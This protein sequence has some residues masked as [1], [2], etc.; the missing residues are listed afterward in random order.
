[1]KKVKLKDI[2][3]VL[4]GVYLRP[5]PTG[6]VTYLQASD[7]QASPSE[8]TTLKVDFV[9]KLSRYL[10][11]KG[12]ILFAGK[13]TKYLCQTFNLDIQAV[14]STTLYMICPNRERVLPEYLC[15]FLNLPQTETTIKAMQVGS[16]MP[17]I[18]KSSLEDLEVPVP[19]LATQSH[20]LKIANLQQRE[21][22]LLSEISEKRAQ[23]TNQILLKFINE[24]K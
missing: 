13:G 10:L 9:P 22:Q 16:S 15:W 3:K 6:E 12:D 14:P 17:M 4:S 23:I 2:S 18:L 20:I 11:Q 19:D 5:S 24:D 8:K 7:L 21:Q 1:M